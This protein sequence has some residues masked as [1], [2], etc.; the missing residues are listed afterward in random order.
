M[1]L[2]KVFEHRSAIGGFSVSEK[3]LFAVFRKESFAVFHNGMSPLFQCFGFPGQRAKGRVAVKGPRGEAGDFPD[4]LEN[5]EA[6]A[7]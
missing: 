6:E 4:G 7:R 2:V 5:A 1:R 3:N